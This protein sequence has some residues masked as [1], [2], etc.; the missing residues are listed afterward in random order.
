VFKPLLPSGSNWIL[1][2]SL[3]K[4]YFTLSKSGKTIVFWW[5]PSLTNILMECTDFNDTGKKYFIAS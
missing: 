3:S 5:I 4:S 2:K 1:P